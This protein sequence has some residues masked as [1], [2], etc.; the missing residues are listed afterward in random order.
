MRLIRWILCKKRRVAQAV[1]FLL[2]LIL[3]LLAW[4]VRGFSD[5]YVA[6]IFPIWLNT[7]GRITGVFS[8]SVGEWMIVLLLLLLCLAAV[9][10]IP[11]LIFRKRKGGRVIRTLY[12]GAF[13]V[14]LP[15]L[16]I[17]TLNCTILYHAT[18]LNGKGDY[19][20]EEL[21]RLYETIVQKANILGDSMNALERDQN[22]DVKAT[23][24]EAIQAMKGLSDQY[25]NLDGYYP[26]TKTMIFS[27]F[28]S[29]QY[30]AGYYFPFSLESNVNG[31]MYCTNYPFT[32]CH[33]LAH[34]RGYIY[35]DEANYLAYLACTGSEDPFFQYSGYLQVLPY[36]IEDINE[37]IM[38]GLIDK[39]ELTLPTKIV[40]QDMAFLTEKMWQVVDS[41]SPLS[42][43]AVTKATDTALELS[44]QLNGVDEGIQSYD[45]VVLLLLKKQ[46]ED[47]K[48]IE[49]E[50]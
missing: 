20:T 4:G 5:F 11:M 2:V 6:N 33:E 35:E 24:K 27:W 18:H 37:G 23:K 41:V 3:N 34:I 1:L 39:K 10:W 28:M 42:T 31:M 36:I 30:I 46:R 50:N 47:T 16:L 29:Q 14:I 48:Q 45:N 8:F 25:P 9:L 49:M 44:L 12:M 38:L 7:Y 21:V 15:V 22:F 19:K 32:I 43:E 40:Y 26:T 13:Q 17:M